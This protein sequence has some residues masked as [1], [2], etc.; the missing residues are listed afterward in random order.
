ME[1]DKFRE[2]ALKAV[3]V[4]RVREYMNLMPFEDAFRTACHCLSFLIGEALPDVETVICRSNDTCSVEARLIR[5]AAPKKVE[6]GI[7]LFSYDWGQKELRLWQNFPMAMRIP[8]SDIST[9][10]KDILA[11]LKDERIIRALLAAAMR[12]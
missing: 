7:V 11:W 8:N 12:L 4:H 5:K 2:E 10:Q 6:N 9:V 3:S 1:D